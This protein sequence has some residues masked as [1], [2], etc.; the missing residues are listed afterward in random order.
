MTAPSRNNVS[1]ILP[2]IA[3][4]LTFIPPG[5][6]DISQ[7]WITGEAGICLYICHYFIYFVYSWLPLGVQAGG[8]FV[9]AEAEKFIT[10][11]LRSVSISESDMTPIAEL[12]E[13]FESA[14]RDFSDPR[15]DEIKFRIGGGRVN[16]E[17]INVKR[18]ML[19]ITG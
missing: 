6:R 15:K 10:T 16:F 8:I 9:N 4:S 1:I 11:K 19:T 2:P 17:V 14:K 7:A 13:E 18:G 3:P 5:Y 12:V